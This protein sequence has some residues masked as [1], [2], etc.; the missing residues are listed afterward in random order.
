MISSGESDPIIIHIPIE[1]VQ[2]R[3]SGG[4]RKAFNLSQG[5]AYLEYSDGSTYQTSNPLKQWFIDCVYNSTAAIGGTYFFVFDPP[6]YRPNPGQDDNG[7]SLTDD[8]IGL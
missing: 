6:G 1:E 8:D 3:T 4:N 5:F 2:V 7:R